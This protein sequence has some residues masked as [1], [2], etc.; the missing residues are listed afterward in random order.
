MPPPRRSTDTGRRGAMTFV[1]VL[2]QRC[3]TAPP[4]PCA[5][6]A[7]MDVLQA[8]RRIALDLDADASARRR[9]TTVL[10]PRRGTAVFEALHR[11]VLTLCSQGRRPFVVGYP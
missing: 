1:S 4:P 2:E 10:G 7:R 11:L 9:F 6:L 8:I 5:R 3:V